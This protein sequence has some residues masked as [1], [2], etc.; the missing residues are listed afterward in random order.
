MYIGGMSGPR[1]YGGRF[2]KGTIGG[3]AAHSSSPRRTCVR[4]I[5]RDRRARPLERPSMFIGNPLKTKKY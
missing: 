2:R 3:A 5:S 1:Q 4:P